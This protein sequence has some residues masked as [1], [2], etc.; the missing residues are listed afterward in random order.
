[1][2]IPAKLLL[3]GEYVILRGGDALA[4]PLPSYS[5]ELTL[6]DGREQNESHKI[7]EKFAAYLAQIKPQLKVLKLD[8]DRLNYE[9]SKKLWF[10]SSIPLKSGL[11]SSGALVAAITKR[12]GIYTIDDLPSLQTDLSLME[13]F[14]HGNSSGIDPLVC[15]MNR[16]IHIQNSNVCVIDLP[17]ERDL[18]DLVSV[19][20]VGHT[21]EL[22]QWFLSKLKE[23]QYHDTIFN[24][25]LP[26][27]N[28]VVADYIA[29]DKSAFKKNLLNLS[30]M[31]FQLFR[32]MISESVIMQW[33]EGLRSEKYAIKLCGS[34]GGGFALRFNI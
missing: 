9:L 15:Y 23:K 3:F 22:V 29:D 34:G 28:K 19:E 12:Y 31:Q 18:P 8:I 30:A 5:G 16:A 4:I 21:G 13:S 20:G 24:Q 27:Q 33:E 25:Y 32:H 14:F 10:N 7:I 2:R 1:M 17:K 11:G 26:L 6:I